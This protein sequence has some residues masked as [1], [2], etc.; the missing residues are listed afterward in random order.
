M[1]FY[2]FAPHDFAQ[3]AHREDVGCSASRQNTL[4]IMDSGADVDGSA[5][6]ELFYIPREHISFT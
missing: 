3:T 6:K 2:L 5:Q 4:S 1:R